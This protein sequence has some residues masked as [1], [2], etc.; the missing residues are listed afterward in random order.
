M[1]DSTRSPGRPSSSLA[2]KALAFEID[3]DAIAAET[4]ALHGEP[5]RPGEQIDLDLD[6]DIT[7]LC[8]SYLEIA[9]GL[10]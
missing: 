10:R 8:D 1:A 4:P 2:T 3:W 9:E 7:S 6:D 5:L